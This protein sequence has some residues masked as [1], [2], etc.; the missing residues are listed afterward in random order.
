M[1]VLVL[2]VKIMSDQH[3]KVLFFAKFREQLDCDELYIEYSK[4]SNVQA[5]IALLASYGGVWAEVFTCVNKTVDAKNASLLIAV[6]QDMVSQDCL[7][8]AGDEVAFFPPVT[9]G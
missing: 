6:N 5:L 2:G 1:D 7:L 9:G 8:N 4:A 3:I